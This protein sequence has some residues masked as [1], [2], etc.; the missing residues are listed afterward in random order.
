MPLDL[1]AVHCATS[2]GAA[3]HYTTPIGPLPSVTTILDATKRPED[4]AGLD[5]WRQRVGHEE[6][7]RIRQESAARGSLLH[8]A[9]E[10]WTAG[11]AQPHE[12]DPIRPW[13]DSLATIRLDM[14]PFLPAHAC[15]AA[16]YHPELRYA[17]T[18]DL[19][20][21]FRGHHVI[22]DWKTADRPKRREW[23]RDYELQ[24]AAYVVAAQRSLRLDR[25]VVLDSGL[26]AIALPDRPAQEICMDSLC[27][28]D[29]FEEFEERCAAFW[30]LQ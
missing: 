18:L 7:E 9:M 19:A 10:A 26:V 8:A 1:A 30:R 11:R 20:A 3:R 12:A 6:A 16:V 14:A 4:R 22:V 27:V 21:L 25:G 13:W 29:A 28:A 5:A 15:E 17:G 23:C 2:D 24:V